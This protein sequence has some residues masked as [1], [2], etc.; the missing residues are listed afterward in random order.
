MKLT[1]LGCSGSVPAPG[2]P[3]SGYL[4]TVDNDESVVMDLGPGTLAALQEIQNPADAHV[5][6]THLH[7][8]H[9]TDFPSLMVWRRFHPDS[10]SYGRDLCFGPVDTPTHLGRLSSNE[11]GGVD[12]MSDTFAFAPWVDGQTEILGRVTI[13]PYRVLHP[14]EAYALRV[15]EPVSG[16]VI[17][18]SGDSAYTPNLVTAARDADIFFAEACW[19]PSSEGMAPGMHMSGAEAG[20]V[21]REAGVGHLV[22]IH[23]QPWADV[24]ATLAAAR[25]EFDGRISVGEPGQVYAL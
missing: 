13:T 7:A 1:I 14:V 18:Y 10:A 24:E 20:R 19:G 17:T 21:A 6:F 23:I 9:C 25:T 22:L 5:V 3:A 4:I 2:K 15:R 16:K 8:D 12:D 11:P